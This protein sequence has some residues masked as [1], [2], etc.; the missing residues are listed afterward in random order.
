M[1]MKDFSTNDCFSKPAH[2]DSANRT[3]MQRRILLLLLSFTILSSLCSRAF[4]ADDATSV[5]PDGT[6]ETAEAWPVKAPAERVEEDGNHFLR[7]QVAEPGKAVMDYRLANVKPDHKAYELSY[8]VRFADIKRGKQKWFDGRIMMN[9]KDADGKK[10]SSP[11]APTFVG[12]SKGWESRTTSFLVPEGAAEL[13]MMFTLFQAKSGTLEFD[14]IKLVPTDPEPIRA[15]AAARAAAQAAERE[16]RAAAVKPQV[17]PCP[18][19]LM[20]KELKVVGNQIQTVEGQTVW[21]QGISLCSLEWSASGDNILKSVEVATKEWKSNVLRQPIRETFWFG[22]GDYQKDG[23]A[24]Y[25]Q[26]VDDSINLAAANGAYVV[27]DLHQFRAPKEDHVI[28]WQ[29]IAEKYKNHPAVLFELFNE[30]HDISW[31]VWRNGGPVADQKKVAEAKKNGEPLAENNEKLIAFRSVGMQ[32]LIDVIRESGANNI[33]VVGGLDWGYDLSGIL[34]G[35]ALDDKGGNGIVYSS[36]VYPWKSDWQGKFLDLADK[37]P[38]FIGE[39]GGEVE[40]MPFIPPERHEDP[41]TWAPDMLGL[42]QKHKLHWT[43]WCFHTKSSPRLLAD[44]DYTP[45]PY[46]GQFVKDALAGKQFEI[47]RMR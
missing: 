22:R 7:L 10:L 46:W 40:R 47:K 5:L 21:L 16:R 18:P 1:A 14:D 24:G 38:L 42:I 33:V 32:K 11:G 29:A 23:G 12:T 45:T 36:H 13:E 17:P 25:R 30:P 20:P 3:T 9:F 43:G 34:N 37:Y 6:F 8:R 39:L 2:H 44:W 28:F 35:Y 31:E 4:A 27:L 26:L 19:E 15:A 41:Y